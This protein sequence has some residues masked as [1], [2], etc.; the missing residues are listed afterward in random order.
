MENI[1][2]VINNLANTNFEPADFEHLAFY[3]E[4]KKRIE[5]HL[6]ARK[7]MVITFNSEVDKIYIKKGETIHTENSHKF[8]KDNIKPLVKDNGI[9]LSFGWNSTGVGKEGFI[10]EEI[11]LVSHGGP[12]ND[13]ICVAQRKQDNSQ[14][15]LL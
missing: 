1:L 9:V 5:M 8:N 15:E 7:D 12:H 11:M 13:T 2:N 3:N 10:T 6:K 14:G 4:E